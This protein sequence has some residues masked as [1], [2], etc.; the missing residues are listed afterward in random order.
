[1]KLD[2]LSF[3]QEVTMSGPEQIHISFRHLGADYD[4]KLVKDA[5][6]DHSVQINS[7]NYAV[8]G[9][10]EKLDTACEILNTI[11]LDSITNVEELKGRL[12]V[13]K[14]I[15]FPTQKTDDIGIITLKTTSLAPVLKLPSRNIETAKL[16]HMVKNISSDAD[17]QALCRE[18]LAQNNNNTKLALESLKS[19][20][21]QAGAGTVS[22]KITDMLI[23]EASDRNVDEI[24]A[25]GRKRTVDVTQFIKALPQ[26][27]NGAIDLTKMKKIGQ[28]GTQDVFVLKDGPS[29]FVIK[30]NRASLKMKNNERLEKY[31]TDNA[32]YQALHNSFGDHC[33]VEQLLLREVADDS[34]TKKA[35]VS[36]AD[37]EVGFQKESKLGLQ[38]TD[39][40]WNDVTI[41]KHLDAYDDMLKSVLFS[42][43]APSFDL[44]ILE[45]MNPK[46]GKIVYLIKQEPAF[47]DALKEFLTEF[48]EYFNKTGQYLD[49]AGRDNIIFFKDDKGW[50]FK[51]GTVIKM[52][53]AK[54]FE[55]SLN[56]LHNGSKETEESG[57]HMSMLRY[58][59]HWTKTLNTLAMMVGMDRVIID[60]NVVT[61]WSDLEKAEITGKPS[62]PQRFLNI[63]QA[64]ETY[65]ADKLLEGFKALDVNPEKEADCLLAI[66]SD[67]PPN[68]KMALAQYL[69]QVLP[70]VPDDTKANG[71]E[72]YKFCYVRYNIAVD[73]G[74]IPEGKALALEC[75]GEVMKDPQGP[76]EE[77]LKAINEL[78]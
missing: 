70:R 34:G 9:E 39:F 11:S 28:G 64:V 51:L 33:T 38:A 27:A 42:E 75:F 43:N 48:K 50:T 18:C 36:V 6:S 10:K 22:V 62:N 16:I 53:T 2:L 60:A 47:R 49:I 59:F 56:W 30:V 40:E 73:I 65:P 61:M 23:N 8:L 29:P 52:E 4:I 21:Y 26:T 77:V 57:N 31:K 15:S 45:A 46:V 17:V 24:R 20:F 54:K 67:S 63:L 58:C 25:F 74:K 7:S 78:S 71:P 37:F 55:A 41:A 72:A 1:M 68:K 66:L 3:I 13:L 5:K 14:D 32:A 44:R 12:S 69:H 76:R 35:I 19:A